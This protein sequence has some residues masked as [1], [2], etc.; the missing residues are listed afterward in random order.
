L[1]CR[2]KRRRALLESN[3]PRDSPVGLIEPT[4]RAASSTCPA[5]KN[6]WLE[7]SPMPQ[8]TPAR[9]AVKLTNFDTPVLHFR[10]NRNSSLDWR[11]ETRSMDS[12]R[13]VRHWVA[14]SHV[15]S[16]DEQPAF[17][18]VLVASDRSRCRVVPIP[19]DPELSSIQFREGLSVYQSRVNG[20]LELSQEAAECRARD[21]V[22][23]RPS[24][25][26]RIAP[27]ELV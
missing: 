24:R 13:D 2:V 5:L 8:K 14:W 26:W 20:G 4:G 23:F 6:R 22:V 9:R 27:S 16:W 25:N 7:R 12:P 15:V 17:H 21:L 10:L 3:P 1:P 18:G 11:D 19:C